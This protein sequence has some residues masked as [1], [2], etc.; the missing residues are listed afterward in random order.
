MVMEWLSRKAG[1]ALNSYLLIQNFFS[2]KSLW[3]KHGS[4]FGQS[5]VMALDIYIQQVTRKKASF[6]TYEI[7]HSSNFHSADILN[8]YYVL[9]PEDKMDLISDFT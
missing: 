7:L 6:D 5:F 4:F 1:Q 2:Q 8:T 3:S 9:D